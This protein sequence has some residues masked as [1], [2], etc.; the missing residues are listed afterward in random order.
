M[1]LIELEGI[2]VDILDRYNH[3]INKDQLD[4]RD[5]YFVNSVVINFE[6][7]LSMY[8]REYQI[9]LHDGFY[10]SLSEEEKK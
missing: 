3:R 5:S 9:L 8:H 1:N 10:D 4:I 2:P 7:R 6:G